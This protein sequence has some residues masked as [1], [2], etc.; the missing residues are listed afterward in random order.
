MSVVILKNIFVKNVRTAIFGYYLERSFNFT[1]FAN[2]EIRCVLL[3]VFFFFP[4]NYVR[5]IFRLLLL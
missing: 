3:I 2:S 1:F 5:V 4:H